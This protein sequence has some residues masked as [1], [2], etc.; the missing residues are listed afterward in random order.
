[1]GWSNLK[2]RAYRILLQIFKRKILKDKFT[3]T[4]NHCKTLEKV[5]FHYFGQDKQ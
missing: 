5:Y 1:M 2:N 3:M 4:N